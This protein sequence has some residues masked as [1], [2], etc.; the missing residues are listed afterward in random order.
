MRHVGE[1]TE[2]AVADRRVEMRQQNM[3]SQGQR[4]RRG[5]GRPV[6]KEGRWESFRK[7]AAQ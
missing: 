2:V 3:A 6:A 7:G 1:I 4:A 5:G